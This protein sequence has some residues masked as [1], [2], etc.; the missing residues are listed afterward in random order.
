[1]KQKLRF[2]DL[3]VSFIFILFLLT[4]IVIGNIQAETTRK[5]SE[6]EPEPLQP[7]SAF[8]ETPYV[9]DLPLSPDTIVYVTA[10]GICWHQTVE[11]SALKNAQIVGLPYRQALIEGRAPCKLCVEQSKDTKS[12]EQT[13]LF[14]ASLF[15]F[16][17]SGSASGSGSGQIERLQNKN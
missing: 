12:E 17:W 2:Q 8:E 15:H 6:T 11:C 5:K 9:S 10:S 1:M 14:E 4:V 3:M 13:F 7:K 16:G